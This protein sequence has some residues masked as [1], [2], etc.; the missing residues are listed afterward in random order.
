MFL[1]LDFTCMLPFLVFDTLS[2]QTLLEDNEKN[3]EYFAELADKRFPVLF[4]NKSGTTAID[5]ALSENQL[6]S[7]NLMV[8]YVCKYQNEP[9]YFH[10]F[11]HNL[12][13]MILSDVKLAEL[14]RSNVLSYSFEYDGWP[15]LH[16]CEH[17]MLAPYNG[18]VF[19]LRHNY[20]SVFP[21]LAR[22][23]AEVKTAIDEG[24][25]KNLTASYPGFKNLGS[26]PVKSIAQ[27]SNALDAGTDEIMD[28][29]K[30]HSQNIRYRCIMLPAVDK[31]GEDGEIT[32]MEALA[33]SNQ[34][35]LFNTEL[36]ADLLDF[37]WSSY[38]S[39]IHFFS[40][41]LHTIYVLVLAHYIKITFLDYVAYDPDNK[42]FNDIPLELRIGVT[43]AELK[44]ELAED[45]FR[46]ED[47]KRIYPPASIVHLTIFA[48][49]LIW[50]LLYDGY[51]FCISGCAYF[52]QLWNYGDMAHIIC[53]Y[54]NIPA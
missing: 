17:K 35:D 14:F 2:I 30:Q 11:E 39:H 51:Q 50:P 44:K 7:V 10:L 32:V 21:E 42:A 31:G 54:I 26:T 47:D 15:L 19:N 45:Y 12:V 33:E 25:I 48:L 9:S 41:M 36:I 38:G 4:R 43:E 22:A 24:T 18:S 8:Q 27:S 23:Q 5:Q 1:E 40:A 16:T 6:A 49:C 29:V 37:K 46:P 13:D 28:Q 53:G 3:Q 34:L 20:E 52:T